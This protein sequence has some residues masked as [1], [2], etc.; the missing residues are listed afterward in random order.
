M[1]RSKG[2]A[3]S[4]AMILVTGLYGCG[5]YSPGRLS[6]GEYAIVQAEKGVVLEEIDGKNAEFRSG[7]HKLAPGAHKILLGVNRQI[8]SHSSLALDILEPYREQKCSIELNAEPGHEYVVGTRPGAFVISDNLPG[9]AP[10]ERRILAIC[11][12]F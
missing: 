12:H 5:Y 4:M 1:F 11:E 7:S 6:E 8:A 10:V 9:A 3:I 2:E